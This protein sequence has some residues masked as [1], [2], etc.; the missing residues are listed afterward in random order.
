MFSRVIVGSRDILIVAPLATLLG[1]IVGTCLGLLT[2]YSRGLTDDVVSRIIEAFLALPL[3][4][5]AMLVITALGIS[6]TTVIIVI[7]LSFG[8][9]SLAQCAPPC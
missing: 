2:G 5:I 4:I 9:S 3:L 7:G 1:T 6:N 8:P